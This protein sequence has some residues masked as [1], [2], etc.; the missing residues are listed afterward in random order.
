[1]RLPPLAVPPPAEQESH[2][3]PSVSHPAPRFPKKSISS[4][5]TLSGSGATFRPHCTTVTFCTLNGL[6]DAMKSSLPLSSNFHRGPWIRMSCSISDSRVDALSRRFPIASV[7]DATVSAAPIARYAAPA[8]PSAEAWALP[9]SSVTSARSWSLLL[10]N[11][12]PFDRSFPFIDEIL[13]PTP[14]SPMTPAKIKMMLAIWMPSLIGDGPLGINSETSHSLTSF[15]WSWITTSISSATPIATSNVNHPSHGSKPLDWL[16]RAVMSLSKAD[17]ELCKAE[18]ELGRVE[19]V[20]IM[21]AV[22]SGSAILC[23]L[24]VRLGFLIVTFRR[25]M[26]YKKSLIRQNNALHLPL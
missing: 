10:R 19:T 20:Q 3:A 5:H 14:N 18:A 1:M 6:S 4:C 22:I 11:S 24:G 17:M 15:L 21:C 25:V 12:I 7:F 16:S 8:A 13:R 2:T 23:L 9:A 26:A